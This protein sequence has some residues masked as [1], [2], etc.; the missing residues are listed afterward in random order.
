M[1]FESS[2]KQEGNIIKVRVMEQYRKVQYP[3]AQYEDFKKIINA[4]ADFNKVT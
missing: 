4:A 1:G 2:Y 3:I